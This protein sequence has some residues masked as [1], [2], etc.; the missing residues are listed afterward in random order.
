LVDANK[1]LLLQIP[2]PI[3]EQFDA[4]N[5]PFEWQENPIEDRGGLFQQQTTFLN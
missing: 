5:E 3:A 4:N 2:V 1:D